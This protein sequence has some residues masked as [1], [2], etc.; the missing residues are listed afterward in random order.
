MIPKRLTGLM[1]K[2]M[3]EIE[4]RIRKNVKIIPIGGKDANRTGTSK[5]AK[6]KSTGY[7]RIDL[8]EKTL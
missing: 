8:A 7:R 1:G 5:D 6:L 4:N 3:L 2:E